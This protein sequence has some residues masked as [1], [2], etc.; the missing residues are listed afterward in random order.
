[1]DGL[2]EYCLRNL[3]RLASKARFCALIG[4]FGIISVVQSQADTSLRVA[5]Y[6][7]ELS[8]KGPGL[9]LR[10]IQRGEDPQIIAILD[11]ISKVAPDIVV[12]ASFDWD[13][14]NA[15]LTAFSQALETAGHAMP[16]VFAAQPNRGRPTGLDLNGNGRFHEAEDAQGFARFTGAD[17]LAILSRWPIVV[18]EI[19]NASAMLWADL[20]DALLP[21]PDSPKGLEL[22]K[23]LSTTA[24][25]LIPVETPS[26]G[27]AWIGTYFATAPVFDGPEDRNG[28]RSH[29]ETAFWTKLL[30][31]TLPFMPP[32]HLI[33]AGHANL[34]PKRGEGRCCAIRDLLNNPKTQDPL[35][36]QITVDWR[37]DDLEN[38]RV[39][40]MLPDKT[41]LVRDAGIYWPDPGTAHG[42][43]AATAS[44]H[45]LIWVDVAK[46]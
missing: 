2:F 37:R 8:R 40:Y 25:W 7:T 22:I 1:M 46:P 19:I 26:Q 33:I 5:F 31:K 6:H 21:Y 38:M 32:D 24:H 14:Y 45:R 9:L 15:A 11:V 39:S 34:D 44:R 18:P 23:T 41:W 30:D 13:E 36:D 16:H 35:G 17:G 4:V 28:R 43:Q 29:D 20:P 10:D 42:D 27:R 3:R 12:L